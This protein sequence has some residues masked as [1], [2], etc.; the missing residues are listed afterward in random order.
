[1]FLACKEINI[2]SSLLAMLLTC[3]ATTLGTCRS[4]SIEHGKEHGLQE[5]GFLMD[6]SIGVGEINFFTKGNFD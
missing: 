2:N 4:G 3:M 5:M 6:K 1:V